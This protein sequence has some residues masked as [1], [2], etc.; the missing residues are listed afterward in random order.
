MQ[1]AVYEVT[2]HS[3]SG[4]RDPKISSAEPIIK[5]VNIL[6]KSRGKIDALKANGYLN[7]ISSDGK[8]NS[9]QINGNSEF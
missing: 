8:Q 7:A 1:Y 6:W 5:L 2:E 3:F 9:K 4:H